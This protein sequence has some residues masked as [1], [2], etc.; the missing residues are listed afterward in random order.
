MQLLCVY[1]ALAFSSPGQS[2]NRP[3]GTTSEA[4][5]NKGRLAGLCPVEG[6]L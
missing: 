3:G 2:A 5:L 1:Y 4:S 6:A